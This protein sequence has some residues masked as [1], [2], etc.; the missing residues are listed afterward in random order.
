[1]GERRPQTNQQ[2]IAQE[3]SSG[4]RWVNMYEG[5]LLRQAQKEAGAVTSRPSP[6]EGRPKGPVDDLL[7]SLIDVIGLHK[8]R[9]Q[10][11]VMEEI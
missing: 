3:L 10:N 1:M 11:G 7:K 2:A 9:Q 5:Q 4:L 8:E 6:A